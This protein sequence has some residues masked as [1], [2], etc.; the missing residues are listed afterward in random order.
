MVAIAA[1]A[2]IVAA[3]LLPR[4]P[5][6]ARDALAWMLGSLVVGVA[7]GVALGSRWS[8]VAAP[9]VAIAAFELARLGTN[10]PTVDAV[11]VGSIYG[12]I[13]VVVGRG[14]T[15]LLSVPAMMLGAVLGVELAA[16][17]GRPRTARLGLFSGAAALLVALGLTG[18]ALLVAQP[19]TTEPIAGDEGQT[20][21]SVAELVSVA[22][23]GHDQVLLIRGRDVADPV[24]LH[25][26]GGPGGTDIGAMRTD[27]SLEQDFV[28]ATWEQRGTGKS[29]A[30]LDPAETLTLERAVADTIEVTE[31]LRQRFGKER[32][33]LTG[34]SWGTLLGVLAVQQRPDLFHAW[35]GTGQMVSPAA[36][37]IMF[38]EDT[39]TWAER[40]GAET[41]LATLRANG[42]PP[43]ADILRYEAALSH[44]HDWNPYPEF[45]NDLELPAILF[46]P[47]YDLMD[48]INGMRAFL[49]TF[50]VLY[51][52]LQDID[53]RVDV[54]RLEVPVYMVIGAHEARGRAVPADGWFGMLDAPS[55]ERVVFQ[56]SGHRPPFEEP[57]AFA[58]LMRRVRDETSAT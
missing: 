18:V 41:L 6:S 5:I 26:A 17:T 10:G 11:H 51:P 35:V 49:D 25:L 4:G 48:R 2:G 16:R 29:Y 43:Y 46:V 34:N 24:V 9:A 13:A 21:D 15:F 32:I 38:W 52:Q 20:T 40:T 39:V 33:L 55:K 31:Y 36:T 54:P 57:D 3:Q 47:E 19:A 14:V 12:I 42:P 44:E 23:G 28:V 7:C 22:I 53:F 1:L 37:D 50:S 27:V 30:A 56:H 45:D 8:V 58:E